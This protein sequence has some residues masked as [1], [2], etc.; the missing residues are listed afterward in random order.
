[1]MR[2]LEE[3]NRL[4]IDQGR[5][6]VSIGI[7]CNTG[8][9][10]AGAIGSSRT[11]QYTVIGD[12]VNIAARLCSLAKPGEI[13]ISE[14]S[15]PA[16][17]RELIFDERTGRT[18]LKARD[19]QLYTLDEV[20]A[21]ESAARAGDEAALALL[22]SLDRG[23]D[24]F[25][26]MALLHDCPGVPS[27]ARAGSVAPRLHRRGGPRTHAGRPRAA[28]AARPPGAPRGNAARE[29]AA[30]TA[31]RV[32]RRGRTPALVSRWSGPSGRGPRST[33]R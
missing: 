24:G 16:T 20:E 33:P 29:A 21:A 8:S 22:E 27:R 23:G 17:M 5:E 28:A 14:R 3:F 31:A 26:P 15:R 11:L 25:D 6:K 2:A 30:A 10:I 12:A 18:F 4:R 32:T 13:I 9:V 7:G 1:M 19:Q